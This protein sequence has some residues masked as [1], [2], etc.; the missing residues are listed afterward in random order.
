M[1]FKVGFGFAKIC[2]IFEEKQPCNTAVKRDPYNTASV[3]MSVCLCSCPSP[4]L[5]S[6]SPSCSC[7]KRCFCS[8]MDNLFLK[9]KHE[10]YYLSQPFIAVWLHSWLKFFFFSEGWGFKM[11]SR[12]SETKLYQITSNC[13]TI[14]NRG[15]G[16]VKELDKL[17][18][19]KI[20][21]YSYALKLY[22]CP[23]P[24]PCSFW[25]L[26]VLSSWMCFCAVSG[27]LHSARVCTYF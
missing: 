19:P 21:I 12:L 27:L 10:K 1:I 11:H 23:W 2:A 13:Y 26:G 24:S 9:S 4:G 15:G 17:L 25:G 5:C 16:G 6:Y 7:L 20:E 22:D 8:N 18:C 3:S 14:Y